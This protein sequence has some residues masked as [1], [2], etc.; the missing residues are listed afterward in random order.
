[1]ACQSPHL[2]YG[3]EESPGLAGPRGGTITRTFI[4][5]LEGEFQ[6]LVP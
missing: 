2:Q 1:M 4:F 6:K 3:W 5:M